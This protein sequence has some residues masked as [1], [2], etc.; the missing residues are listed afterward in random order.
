[1]QIGA[2]RPR[3]PL[4]AAEP[5][6]GSGD[7]TEATHVTGTDATDA[8]EAVVLPTAADRAERQSGGRNGDRDG[9]M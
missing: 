5:P 1:M 2:H 9:A 6:P 8:V 7:A 3:S 4:A